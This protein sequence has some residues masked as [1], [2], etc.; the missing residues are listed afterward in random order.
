MVGGS[1]I[2]YCLNDEQYA[3]WNRVLSSS[4]DLKEF[5]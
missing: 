5:I 2:K 3:H 4:R 1:D